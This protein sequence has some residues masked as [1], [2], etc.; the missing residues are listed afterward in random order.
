MLVAVTVIVV[1]PPGVV[2]RVGTE[3]VTVLEPVTDGGENVQITPV[4]QPDVTARLT[5]V[6]SDEPY[7]MLSE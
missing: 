5:V 2:G 4:G 3:S 1:V 7:C 6:L